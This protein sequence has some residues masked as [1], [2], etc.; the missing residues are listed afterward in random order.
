MTT[1]CQHTEYAVCALSNFVTPFNP[2]LCLWTIP[3][4]KCIASEKYFKIAVTC[5]SYFVHAFDI[6]TVFIFFLCTRNLRDLCG[7]SNEY[8]VYDDMNLVKSVFSL[9]IDAS[10]CNKH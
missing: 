4:E 7:S 10:K 3:Y 5:P 8:N 6:R 2:G 1:F 9:K